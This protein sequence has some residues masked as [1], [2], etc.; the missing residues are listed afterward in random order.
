MAT[1]FRGE[2][3]PEAEASRFSRFCRTDL[4][5]RTMVPRVTA[6]GKAARRAGDE[7]DRRAAGAERRNGSSGGEKL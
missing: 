7:N 4:R 2:K 6:F 5:A 1:D 3:S